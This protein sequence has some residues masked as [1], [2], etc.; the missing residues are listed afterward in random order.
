MITKKL[1][2]SGIMF[3]ALIALASC[4]GGQSEKNLRVTIVE[5]AE[6]ATL[7]AGDRVV[8]VDFYDLEAGVTETP[9]GTSTLEPS[10]DGTSNIGVVALPK[11]DYIMRVKIGQ[12]WDPASVIVALAAVVVDPVTVTVAYADL[13]VSVSGGQRDIIVDLAPG[14]FAL[15]I[16]EDGDSLSNLAELLGTTSP[17][18][19][20]TDGDGVLDGLDLFP[21]LSTEF[22]D[23]D[24]DGVG[25]TI[26]NCYGLS[27]AD[28]TDTDGDHQGD[29]CDTDDDND[30]VSDTA[31]VDLGTNPLVADSDGDGLKDGADNC[32]TSAN[33]DQADTDGDGSGNACDTDDDNDG[34]LDINDNCPHF[35]GSTDQTDS[36]GDGVGDVCTGD[37]DGDGV[38]DATDNCRTISNAA[39]LD[40]DEDGQGDAGDT[41][42]DNDGL[43]DVEE[44]TPS[45][46]NLIT[47]PLSTDTD[48]DGVADA[49]DNC[50][51]TNIASQT[52]TD[53]D[54][55]GD[56]CDCS[57]NDVSIKSNDA[58]FVSTDGNDANSGARNS[59]VKTIARGI[60]LAQA[61]GKSKVYVVE[62]SYDASVTMANGI[63]VY[64]G[65]AINAGG[66]SCEKDVAVHVSTI[67]SNTSPVVTFSNLTLTTTLEG[68]TVIAPNVPT[69]SVTAVS[70]TNAS[71]F[72]T[73]NNID[74]GNSQESTAVVLLGSPAASFVNNTIN[75]G[76]ST[77]SSTVIQSYNSAPSFVGNDLFTEGGNT[78][79]ILY[80]MD[81]NPLA[82][83]TIVCQGNNLIGN[84]TGVD[85]PKLYQIQ[86][87]AIVVYTDIDDVNNIDGA[88]GNFDGNT[89]L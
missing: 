77:S 88:G 12:I 21:N 82:L 66:S 57:L 50:R 23:G 13:P 70:V 54:G 8:G 41:D 87:P 83:G 45:N 27:N 14:D 33:A 60:L 62:G 18:K 86:N 37:D 84:N 30:G 28:Q 49:V 32:P 71:P 25:D 43:S 31:E 44:T 11:G 64:G 65:F 85:S 9:V 7:D 53:V 89:S 72:F 68:V 36:N 39:Q 52:D 3:T 73:N 80:F 29:A 78:Q 81:A 69:E 4:G 26:D 42:D 10:T 47:N 24:L 17:L 19:A 5:P 56:V 79:R 63:S 16:D 74:A 55:E 48:G 34:V 2:L 35:A 75:G 1:Y 51:I 58:V 67:T 46:D 40:T 38:L 61:A 76:G 22:G 59:R 6:L 20:D 15:T